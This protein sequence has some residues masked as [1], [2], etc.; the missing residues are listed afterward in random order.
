[1]YSTFEAPLIGSSMLRSS[2][3]GD[4]LNVWQL[5]RAL[6]FSSSLWAAMVTYNDL[7]I[8]CKS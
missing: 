3:R 1:M 8:S 4:A 7:R 5:D 6:C 2:L